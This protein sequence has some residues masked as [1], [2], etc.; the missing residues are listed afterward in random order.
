MGGEKGGVF[1]VFLSWGDFFLKILKDGIKVQKVL[2]NIKV[3]G[4]TRPQKGK[5]N[6]VMI[7]KLERLNITIPII[8]D[9]KMQLASAYGIKSVPSIVVVGKDMTPTI[10][11]VETFLSNLNNGQNVFRMLLKIDA[12]ANVGTLHGYANLPAKS[13]KGLL[14]KNFSIHLINGDVFKLNDNLGKYI[15]LYF[16][17]AGDKNSERLLKEL[18]EYAGKHR[19]AT[20]VAVLAVKTPNDRTMGIAS[21][22]KNGRN[23]TLGVDQSLR[24]LKK[25]R[26][27]KLPTWFI[28]D[29][30]GRAVEV[31]IIGV[32]DL[33]RDL[34]TYIGE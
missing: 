27:N 5:L 18:N 28:I 11:N 1:R 23:L 7:N 2:K 16:W 3:Y 13:F 30:Y 32:D 33:K 34:K 22:E 24:L 12:G 17:K 4:V 19:K 10:Y 26:I 21:W 14:L 6:K 25:F 9:E 20:Y 8:I 29:P 31:G 15:V